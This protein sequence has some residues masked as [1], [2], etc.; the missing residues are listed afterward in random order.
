M[1]PRVATTP[2]LWVAADNVKYTRQNESRRGTNEM[3][4]LWWLPLVQDVDILFQ[5]TLVTAT[6]FCGY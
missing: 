4:A 5:S 6:I 1:K 3:T 2:Y